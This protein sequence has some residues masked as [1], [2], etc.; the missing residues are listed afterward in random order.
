MNRKKRYNISNNEAVLRII[1]MHGGKIE[2]EELLKEFSEM[3]GY[4]DG[5]RALSVTFFYLKNKIKREKREIIYY[6]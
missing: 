5:W 4:G 2:K 1:S 3:Q 6:E